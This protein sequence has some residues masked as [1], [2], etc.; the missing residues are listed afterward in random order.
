MDSTTAIR[1]RRSSPWSPPTEAHR[2][3]FGRCDGADAKVGEDRSNR[4][5]V[6]CGAGSRIS[7]A[8]FGVL[9]NTREVPT[10]VAEQLGL[11]VFLL[12]CLGD[13]AAHRSASSI[14]EACFTGHRA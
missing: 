9:M 2:R 10:A 3:L 11:V 4:S 13:D 5:R 8:P 6:H 14:N 1:C 7:S 12:F